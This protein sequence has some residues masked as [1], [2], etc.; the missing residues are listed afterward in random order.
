[1]A[2]L[3]RLRTWRTILSVSDGPKRM[4]EQNAKSGLFTGI[5]Q[6][7]YDFEIARICSWL[8]KNGLTMHVSLNGNVVFKQ[9]GK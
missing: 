9:K 7:Y 5:R 1:M 6:P 4:P 2:D 3:W 8:K